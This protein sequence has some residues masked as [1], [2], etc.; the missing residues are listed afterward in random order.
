MSW[1]ALQISVAGETCDGISQVSVL[2]G[3]PLGMWRPCLLRHPYF[4]LSW[5]GVLVPHSLGL[6]PWHRAKAMLAGTSN[7]SGTLQEKS[8]PLPSPYLIHNP[9]FLKCTGW[10][11]CCIPHHPSSLMWALFNDPSLCVTV[12]LY[13]FFP[14]KPGQAHCTS[15][16]HARIENT[17]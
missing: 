17:T 7:I 16:T 6:T 8:V 1:S 9:C 14:K 10:L 11:Q 4:L 5:E 12:P 2:L 3:P 13:D 15:S